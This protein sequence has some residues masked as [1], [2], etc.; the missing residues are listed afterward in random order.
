MRRIVLVYG[1]VAGAILAVVMFATFVLPDTVDFDR[2][3]VIG[4]TAMVLAF[5]AV[6]FG[7]RA[8]RDE[9]AGGSVRF[10]RAFAVGILITL[11]ASACY[12]A[13]W[14]VIYFGGFAPDFFE[15]YAAHSLAESR[16]DGATDAELAAQV[17]QM[18]RF[19]ELYRNPIVNVGMTL[20]EVFPVGLLVTLV[21]AGVLSRRRGG[22][23]AARPTVAVP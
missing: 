3:E 6:Y 1:L 14:E 16:A 10:G 21:S 18:R 23:A 22:E 11:V 12:V 20:A 2:N 17:A 8:Y 9:V 15:R 4:W 7:I 13:A 5:V 19:A